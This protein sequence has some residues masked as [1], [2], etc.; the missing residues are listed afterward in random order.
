MKLTKLH[1]LGGALFI[2]LLLIPF[3]F[4]SSFVLHMYTLVYFYI[5]LTSAWNIPAF[6]G[7]LSLG[8]ASFF[9]IGAYAGAILYVKC[10]ISPLIAMPVA[11]AA[12]LLGGLILSLPLIRLRGPFFT[13]A[14]IAFAE[15]LRMVAIDW[16]SLTNGSVGIRIPFKVGLANL[17]FQSGRP[18]YYIFLFIAVLVIYLSHRI[19]Y[20]ALGYHLRAGA[21]DSQAAQALGVNTSL[22]NFIALLWS[23]GITGVLGLFYAFYMYVIE[24]STAF[25]LDLFSLQPALNGIIG[26]MGT[27]WGPVVGAILMTPLGEFLRFQLGTIRQGL[28][29]VVYGVVLI[30]TVRYVPGGV[31]SLAAPLLRRIGNSAPST[32]APA[33]MIVV[34]RASLQAA[35]DAPA[36]AT[37][38]ISEPPR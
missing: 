12:A 16:R 14:S 24:P 23:A 9:G 11:L 29:F 31:T 22:A 2:M 7:Q 6:G 34:A 38:S 20:S 13:L 19:R 33:S 8:H 10:G 18:F 15:V 26:G 36:F 21:S 27:I 1:L 5:A 35:C 4:R 30:A 37:R 3:F 32:F 17:T 25:S 28:N